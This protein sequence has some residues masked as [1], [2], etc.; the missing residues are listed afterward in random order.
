MDDDLDALADEFGSAERAVAITG[1]GVSTASGIP[2][3]RGDEGIWGGAFDPASFEIAR[4]ERDPAGFWIDRLALHDRMRPE[5]LEPND[6]HRAL[7]RLS[8]ANVI[9]AVITQNTDGLHAAAGTADVIELHGNSRRAVCHGCGRKTDATAV[10]DRVRNGKTPPR[11][12]HCEG[13][14]K[15]D[16]VLFGELLPRSAL[17]GAKAHVG[18]SDVVLVAGSSL[19][20]HPAAR[21]PRE[22]SGATLAIVNFDRTPFSENA[23]YDLRADVTEVLPAI[24]DRVL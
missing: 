4:F 15:P 6:A 11:C 20:V 16:V 21:L 17:R 10:R 1:A 5:G 14:Y 8:N 9:D 3:F 13:V 7:A 2:P 23:D 18:A 24:A 12:D 22:R 19:T